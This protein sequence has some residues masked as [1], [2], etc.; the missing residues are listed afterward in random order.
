MKNCLSN[1]VFRL[2]SDIVAE[3]GQEA[4]VIGGYVRDALLGRPSKDIDIVTVGNGIELAREVAKKLG[5]QR[6]ITVYRNFGT[7]ML[8]HEG[9]EI[10]FVG[11][12]K[13]S[14][15]NDSR[16]P[17]VENGSLEDDQKRRDF[18]VNALA[19][20]LNKE[21]FGRL[22]DPFSGIEDLRN[23]IIRTPLDPEATFSDDPLR[24]LRA[25]RFA[26]QLEFNIEQKT[27]NALANNRERI[28]IVSAERIT[29]E[30][31]KILISKTPSK[32]FTLL[33]RSGLL[34]HILPELDNLKGVE[35][36][37][38]KKHKDN[39]LHTVKVV[40][41]VSRLSDNLW[42]RWAAL[43]HDIGKPATKRYSTE[44]GWSF[45]GHDYLGAKMV[46]EIFKKLR[47]PLNDKMKYVKK[48]VQLHLR[49][50]NL[51]KEEI[52]DSAIRRLLYEAGDDLEDL[53]LLCEADITS[54]NREIVKKYLNNFQLV[55]EKLKEIEEKD[56]I[57]NFQPPVKGEEIMETFGI[58]PCR[59]VGKIKN[60]IK[61]AIIEGTIG[62][63]YPQAREFML[64]KG[65]EL[66]LTPKK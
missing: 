33:E 23:K 41:S 50:I 29:D 66:G 63:N 27:F 3:K 5:A 10:E 58:G 31:N 11:A 2:I 49:P 42:L 7:A 22:S 34:K 55:R 65:E 24:M 15:R 21:S 60:A 37:E 51:A 46:P 16:K 48:M 61:E 1:R 14:Y 9:Y 30:L 47:L 38:G 36:R 18:T 54:Q 59:E 35:I 26:T 25:V 62:N 28:L 56:A 53:M 44:T 52:T 12:R 6:K 17:V 57:R 20:S 13:E 64:K 4:Y 43:L 32:G 45:H 19:I 8:Q 40:D 39:F